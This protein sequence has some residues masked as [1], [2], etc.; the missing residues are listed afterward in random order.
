MRSILFVA[1][2]S[3]VALLDCNGYGLNVPCNVGAGHVSAPS[4]SRQ[5]FLATIAGAL[6]IGMV[7]AD[8]A[9]SKDS[10]STLGTKEDPIY[11]ACLSQC[12]LQVFS[13]WFMMI[14]M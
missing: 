4:V 7:S 11:Q 8:V 5:N 3:V 1:T 14:G 6:T 10:D 9:W 13:D 2:L 12:E